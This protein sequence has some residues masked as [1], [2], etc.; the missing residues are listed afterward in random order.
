MAYERNDVEAK[1]A[2]LHYQTK[3]YLT[4]IK[5]WVDEF[6]NHR[7][8]EYYKLFHLFIGHIPMIPNKRV[9]VLDL[10]MFRI[11]EIEPITNPYVCIK[12]P[13]QSP[14]SF[15]GKY[16]YE[17]FKQTL[18]TPGG[19]QRIN[20][21]ENKEEYW[22]KPLGKESIEPNELVFFQI[23]RLNG[24]LHNR[25]QVVSWDLYIVIN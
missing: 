8:T 13:E 4:E 24:S 25:M 18:K 1:I 23:F 11:R 2:E 5:K 9:Y 14:F 17:N 3:A 22:L 7:K 12:I 15:S 6:H 21:K 10:T 16:V 20:E 19:W